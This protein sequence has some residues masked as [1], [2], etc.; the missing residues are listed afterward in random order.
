MAQHYPDKAY[1]RI[2][3]CQH[4]SQCFSI[5][6]FLLNEPFFALVFRQ[7]NVQ[8]PIDFRALVIVMPSLIHLEQST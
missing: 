5:I 2:R 6:F 1:K 3:Q 4:D 8:R 7:T